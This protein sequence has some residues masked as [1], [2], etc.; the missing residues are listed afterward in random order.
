M[1]ENVDGYSQS[2]EEISC[3]GRGNFGKSHYL[4]ELYCEKNPLQQVFDFE[5]IFLLT[6]RIGLDGYS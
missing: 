2:Y 6:F 3:I 4:F 5:M 1:V